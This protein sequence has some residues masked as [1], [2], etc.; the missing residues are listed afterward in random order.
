MMPERA[1]SRFFGHLEFR[2]MTSVPR[3]DV[4]AELELALADEDD[5]GAALG[6][7]DFGRRS[8]GP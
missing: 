8:R 4:A 3:A 5:A 6:A 7:R 1:E 2:R